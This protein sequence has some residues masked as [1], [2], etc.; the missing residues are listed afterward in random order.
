MTTE[1]LEKAWL[2]LS[3]RIDRLEKNELDRDRVFGMKRKTALENLASRYRRFSTI[4][5]ILILPGMMSFLNPVFHADMKW[6]VAGFFAVYMA[7]AGCMDYWL[8]KGVSA[9]D[10]TSMP[11]MEVY[12]RCRFYRRRHHQFM[13]VLI[14]LACAFIA[15]TCYVFRFDDYFIAGVIAGGVVGLILGTVQ[16]FRFMSD[17]KDVISD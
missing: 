15:L 13:L 12:G 9:I 5:F 4:A 6:W 7:L 8:Y 11:V 16:Y 3:D 1:E 10:V 14:P 2:V 17:Y